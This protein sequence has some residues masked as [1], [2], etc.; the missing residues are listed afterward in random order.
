MSAD[1]FFLDTNIFVYSFEY[2]SP[3]KV[4][5]ADRL[6]KQA[7]SS[8]RGAI[9]Y[10]VVQEFFSVALRKFP[11]QMTPANA[12]TYFRNVFRPLYAVNFS[13]ALMFRAIHIASVHQLSWYDSI[14]LAAATESNCQI[15][16][17]EDF[18]SGRTIEGVRIQNPFVSS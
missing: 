3:Q 12:H 16:Y 9:S 1:R 17:S 4:Q 10:Q 5:V 2:S 7:V 14:I 11:T 18:Q 6:I 15:L 13:P 8:G